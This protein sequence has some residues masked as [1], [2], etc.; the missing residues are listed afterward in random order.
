M[1]K[2]DE[3]VWIRHVDFSDNY[4]IFSG[5]VGT[6]VEIIADIHGLSEKDPLFKVEFE[7]GVTG[8][9]WTEELEIVK[10]EGENA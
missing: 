4:R 10:G 8:K 2:V 9:F 7:P 5:K 3:H 6:V 1:I